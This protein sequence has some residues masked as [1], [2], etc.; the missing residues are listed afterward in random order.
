MP[1]IDGFTGTRE[2]LTL[3]QKKK[4]RTCFSLSSALRNEFHFGDCVGADQESF[5]ICKEKDD[6][7]SEVHPKMKYWVSI[8]H[9]PINNKYRAYC[10][11]DIILTPK[12]YHVRNRDIVKATKHVLTVCPKSKKEVLR[13]GTWVY[14]SF[15]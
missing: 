8:A 13:S 2:G 9:P 4:L 1:F 5:E 11:A 7:F 12:E 10:Q 6:H 15:C 14:I 3:A